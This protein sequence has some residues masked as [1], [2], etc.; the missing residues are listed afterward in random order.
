MVVDDLDAANATVDE[1]RR[2]GRSVA[3]FDGRGDAAARSL[4]A[5]LRRLD[6]GD[7]DLIVA[8]QPPATGLGVTIRDRLAKA[9]APRDH[10]R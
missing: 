9:A 8:I 1:A 3:L 2:A 6:Q 10:D 4:Y 7:V 5:E